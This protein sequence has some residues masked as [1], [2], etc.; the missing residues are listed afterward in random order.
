MR[1]AEQHPSVIVDF[2]EA[3][4]SL[5][6]SLRAAGED[7]S[8]FLLS[9][10]LDP[11]RSQNISAT[12]GLLSDQVEWMRGYARRSQAGREAYFLIVSAGEPVG[13][14]R[15]YDYQPEKD[16]FCWGSWIIRPGASPSVAYQ[17][18][19]LV[20]DLGFGSLGFK[21][22]HFDVR[23]A[24]VSVWKF[25]EKMGARLVREDAQDR[26]YEYARADYLAA[27]LRLEKFTQNQT[28]L[29]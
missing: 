21:R 26:F 6:T 12:S 27:R 9:L 22:A 1:A 13:S 19:I 29:Q 14:V 17:S 15:L 7:D 16:S 8:A 23:Q 10:R 4:R 2:L 24:N 18:A 5:P 11:T 25:H 3:R 20:Y 28:F